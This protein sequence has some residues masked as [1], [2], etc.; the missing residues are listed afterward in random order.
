MGRVYVASGSVVSSVQIDFFRLSAP[1]DGAVVIHEIE[2]TQGSENDLEQF[3]ILLHRGTTDGSGGSSVTPAPVHVGDAAFGGSC[4]MGN[5]T[6]ST[7]GTALW[8]SGFSVAGGWTFNPL[9]YG[10]LVLSP[11]GRLVGKL[12][13]APIDSISWE[14]SVRFEEIGG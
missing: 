1:S 6:Q 3:E 5:T 13:S 11:S 2:V 12:M 4:V 8:R 10:R 9:P 14:V 7:E